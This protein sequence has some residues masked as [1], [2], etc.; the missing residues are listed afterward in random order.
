MR[1]LI[2]RPRHQ[3]A[4]LVEDLRRLGAEPIE[5]PLIE[6]LP[7]ED[8]AA[9]DRALTASY[10]WI[11]FTSANAV[12]AVVERGK[13][14]RTTR[15]AAVGPATARVLAQHGLTAVEVPSE[16]RGEK[17]AEELKGVAGKRILLPQANIARSN[18]A[19]RL[20]EKGARVTSVVAY[21]T[22]AADNVHELKRLLEQGIDIVTFFSPS[23]VRSYGSAIG[24]PGARTSNQPAVVCVGPVTAEA[25]REVGLNVDAVAWESTGASVVE[26]ITRHIGVLA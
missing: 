22:V 19:D 23:A 16:F 3:V 2:T 6:I 26:A 11:I 15:I 24:K 12:R 7:L 17:I 18:L 5:L 25:A 10:D 1:V 8:P 13:L 21:R 14:L 9:L 4:E 20:R